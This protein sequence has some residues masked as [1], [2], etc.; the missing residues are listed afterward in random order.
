MRNPN[1]VHLIYYLFVGLKYTGFAYVYYMSLDLIGL[2][3]DWPL[4]DLSYILRLSIIENI[5]D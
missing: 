2:F 4:S 5:V 1:A 3:L